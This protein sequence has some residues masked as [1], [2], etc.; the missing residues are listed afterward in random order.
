MP[1]GR[2]L[3]NWLSSA[4]VSRA[5]GFNVPDSQSGFRAMRREVAAAVRPGGARY[6]FET[7]FLFLAARLGFRVG[8]VS[9]PTVY[10]GA[11][12]HFRYGADTLA[13][14][15]VFFRHWRGVLMG[16]AGAPKAGAPEGRA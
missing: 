7:E 2:R 4:L 8:A 9:V 12:S 1:A 10:D 15:S 6:E 14:A 5:V 13:I 3:S 16:P 11:A